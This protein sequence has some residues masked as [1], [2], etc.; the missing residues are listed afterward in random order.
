[1]AKKNTKNSNSVNTDNLD[2]S[3]QNMSWSVTNLLDSRDSHQ[4]DMKIE[5]LD[6]AKLLFRSTIDAIVPNSSIRADSYRNN[7]VCF[8]YYPFDIG[9][10]FPFS[11]LVVDVLRTLKVSHGQLMPF[12]GR[13]LACLDAIEKKH[14]RKINVEVVKQSYSLK[15]F[16]GCRVGFLNK[17][18]EEPL[19]LNNETVN[20]RN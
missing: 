14:N 17:N 5:K 2:S 12:A 18:T 11:S 9:L 7:W 15:K 3:N 19:I 13:I 10:T 4:S 16:S 20:D 8:Y 1:M 6:E